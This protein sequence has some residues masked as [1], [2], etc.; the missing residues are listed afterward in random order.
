MLKNVT[1]GPITVGWGQMIATIKPSN[2]VPEMMA[3]KIDNI[4]NESSL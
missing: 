4:E 1:A 2:E 3:P